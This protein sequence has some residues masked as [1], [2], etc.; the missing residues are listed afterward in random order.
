MLQNTVSNTRSAENDA[1]KRLFL[2]QIFER[3]R[4]GAA[5]P[6]GATRLIGLGEQVSASPYRPCYQEH[7]NSKVKYIKFQ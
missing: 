4:Y 3:S 7:I 1:G 6:A 2:F 5:G